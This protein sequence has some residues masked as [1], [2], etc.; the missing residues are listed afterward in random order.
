MTFS[1]AVT[2][3]PELEIE[4]ELNDDLLEATE[5]L[6]ELDDELL[7]ELDERFAIELL[8]ITELVVPQAA[9]TPNGD[10][11]LVQ[12]EREMQLLLFS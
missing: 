2:P 7:R 9:T 11:W 4:L 8:L 10:G 3:P 6:S 1:M 12:V 5:L